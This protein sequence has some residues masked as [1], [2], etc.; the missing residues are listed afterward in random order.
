MAGIQAVASDGTSIYATYT[1]V[2]SFYADGGGLNE[3]VV[4][5]CPAFGACHILV[6]DLDGSPGAIAADATNVYWSSWKNGHTTVMKL[7]HD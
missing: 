5:K 3:A 6:T 4:V 1:G 7:A 2:E